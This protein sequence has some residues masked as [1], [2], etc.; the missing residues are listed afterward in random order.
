MIHRPAV[1]NKHRLSF[2]WTARIALLALMV[3]VLMPLTHAL[4]ANEADGPG[5]ASQ[6]LMVVCTASGV[7]LIAVPALGDEQPKPTG[8]LALECPLCLSQL[9]ALASLPPAPLATQQQIADTPSVAVQ[10]ARLPRAWKSRPNLARAPP[11]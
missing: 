2:L 3:Q 10:V 1:R 4:A 11:A 5:R 6:S 9:S 8:M 7:K